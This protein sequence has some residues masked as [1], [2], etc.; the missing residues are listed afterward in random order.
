MQGAPYVAPTQVMSIPASW[1]FVANGIFSVKEETGPD[2]EKNRDADNRRWLLVFG[3]AV[4]LL[5][6][7]GCRFLF[8]AC[9]L[10]QMDMS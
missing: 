2:P 9:G 7:V 3:Q 4:F 6:V 10:R 5:L 8:A 1:F